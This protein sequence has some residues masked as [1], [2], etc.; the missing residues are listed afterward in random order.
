M[1]A[2]ISEPVKKQI[3]ILAAENTVNLEEGDDREKILRTILTMT[4]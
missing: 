3:T 4:D 1:A 2:M